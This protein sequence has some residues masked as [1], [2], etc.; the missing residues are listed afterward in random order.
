M[1]T[2]DGGEYLF[3]IIISVFFIHKSPET[4]IREI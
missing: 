3:K 1:V 2:A 4:A